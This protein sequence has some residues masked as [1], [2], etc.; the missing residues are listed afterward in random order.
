MLV[1]QSR[2]FGLDV[3]DRRNYQRATLEKNLKNAELRFYESGE[4][5]S[6]SNLDIT[7]QTENDIVQFLDN[8]SLL[9]GYDGNVC[10]IK[11]ADVIKFEN[12]SLYIY[13]K[14]CNGIEVYN[15]KI[16]VFLNQNTIFGIKN[17]LLNLKNYKYEFTI[18]ESE[19]RDDLKSKRIL[20]EFVKFKRALFRVDNLHILP[21]YIVYGYEN[22]F[23]RRFMYFVDARTGKLLFKIPLFNSIKGNV[24]LDSPEK[25]KNIT[26][27]DLPDTTDYGVLKNEVTDVF[28][29][30]DPTTNC[31]LSKR[32][33]KPDSEGNYLFS[34]DESDS[35]DPFAEVMA[36]FHLN[37]IYRWFVESGL[38][39]NPFTVTTVVN[40][41]GVGS[42]YDQFFQCNGFYLER[43]VVLGFCPSNNPYNQSG[44]NINI[45]YDADVIMHELVHGFYDEVYK[46]YP[47]IDSAGYSGMIYGINEAL[48]DLIPA[49]I[50][51]DSHTGRHLAKLIKKE[52]LR[53]LDLV[54][55]CPDYLDGEPH[56]DGE[57][58]STA[59][60]N[61]RKTISDKELFTRIAFV[62]IGGLDASASFK[63]FYETLI[64]ILSQNF[65]KETI[66]N[67]KRP[68]VDRNV[69]KCGRYI[70]V[71]NGFVA[72]GYL[73]PST[74]LGLSN[75]VPFEVQ[76]VY[77]LPEENNLV[78][79]D[80]T[81]LSYSGNFST[82]NV[83]FYVNY[84]RPVNYTF[85][86][87][88]ADY[89]WIKRNQTFTDLKPGKYYI[90]PV[91]D[92]QGLYYF[93]I[94][95]AYKEPAPTV[96]SVEP[97]EVKINS[98]IDE[99]IINGKNFQKAANVKL[100]YGITYEDYEV[101]DSNTIYVYNLR[102][103]NE[104]ECGYSNVSVINPDGQKG[105]GKSILLVTKG[106]EKC[107][108]DITFECDEVCKCDPD[109]T[110]GGC[111]CTLIE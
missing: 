69:D 76:F 2:I 39:F 50:T 44:S 97:D 16:R 3:E 45:A 26:T 102:I 36:Y 1:V 57:I 13:K 93:K 67:I 42:E 38:N 65:D 51:N 47:V 15:E 72:R 4:I 75:E 52:S 6:I 71:E 101:I 82:D 41:L 24:Y 73:M 37:R 83:K 91:S 109:C 78:N 88:K 61:A 89:V 54:R 55:K 92:G 68:F 62:S 84:N 104:T 20:T 70:E 105:I 85:E 17:N 80:I 79:V 8:Y 96:D 32:L 108:C 35:L 5:R 27:V 66:D 99:L 9:F 12:I 111:S 86:S 59:L 49:H 11:T 100:P 74:E 90:L 14:F 87:L 63:D 95:F 30:C 107:R 106:N 23:L 53:N 56:N 43:Q 64:S 7:I 10:K 98:S 81:V 46:L 25:D 28:S 94:R 48:A 34:P 33:A 18:R 29:D 31:D 60:W 22:I 21:V 19:L 110:E 77:S 40:F 103:T 58:L